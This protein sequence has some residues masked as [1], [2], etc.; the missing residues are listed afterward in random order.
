VRLLRGPGVLGE[1]GERLDDL[2]AATGAPITARRPWLETWIASYP[3]HTPWAIVVEGPGGLDAVALLAAR[4]G[5]GRTRVVGLGHGPSDH[6][7]LPARTPEAAAALGEA[8]AGALGAIGG[9]WSL[10]IE[11]LPAADPVARE[12]A[13]RLPGGAT[14]PGDGSPAMVFDRGREFATYVS[15]NSRGV[16]STMRNRMRRDGLALEVEGLRDVERVAAALPE[17]E[18][19]HRDRDA[20]LVRRSDLEDPRMARFWREVMVLLAGRGELELLT[21]RLNGALAAYLVGLLDVDSYRMWDGRFAE[22]FGWYSPGRV[23]DQVAFASA[24]GEARFAE[25][26]WMRGEEPYKLRNSSQ[27][28]PA[29]HLV[30]WSSPVVRAVDEWPRRSKEALK[31]ARDRNPHLRSAWLAVKGRLLLRKPPP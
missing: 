15:R 22:A 17:V 21:L 26:D 23:V 1:L 16:A 14:V 4:R 11:Q 18:R 30:A 10:R 8:V 9:P 20:Q 7:R 12:I 27:V 5:G 6:A 24:L 13:R 28:A 2:L 31:R 25:F 3:D 29:E 19:V